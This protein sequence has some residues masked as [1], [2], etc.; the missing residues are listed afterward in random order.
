MKYRTTNKEVKSNSGYVISIPYCDAQDLLRIAEPQAYTCGVYGWNSDIYHFGGVTISTGYRP[1]NGIRPDR[2]LL[3]RYN[4]K[5]AKVFKQCKSWK[6]LT[7]ASDRIISQF[8]DDVLNC[9]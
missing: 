5:A 9:A 2:E 3:K 6:S 4:R 8:I 7:A 1:V